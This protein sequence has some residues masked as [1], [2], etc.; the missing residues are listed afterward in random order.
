MSI[1]QAPTLGELF[2]LPEA[3]HRGDFV[4]NLAE[5]AAD[6]G[7]PDDVLD[8]YVVTD[9]IRTSFDKALGFIRDGINSN[10]SR[11]T[12]L[13]GSFGSGKSHFMAV[14]YLLLSQDPRARR[15]R[16]LQDLCAAHQWLDG[17]KFLL[18][19]YH[20]IAQPS[21]EACLL[22]GYVDFVRKRHPGSALPA[23]YLTEDLLKN[24]EEMRASFGDEAF[25]KRLSGDAEASSVDDG[26]G[27]ISADET[28]AWDLPTYLAA[29][30]APPNSA[31]R[32]RLVTALVNTVLTAFRGA[33]GQG[34]EM[35]VP[36]DD[37]LTAISEHAKS[38]G[39]D[40][41]VLFCDELI[42]WL[43]SRAADISF[44]HQE[45]QKL[46][47]LV[48]GKPRALPIISFMARQRDLRELV[49][50]NVLG[51]DKLHFDDAFKH[52][53]GRFKTI[54]LEDTNLP[55][56]ASQRVLR[57]RSEKAREAID[58]AFSKTWRDSAQARS[59]LLSETGTEQDFRKV[60]PF[61]PALIETLIAVSSILQ[62]QRTALKVLMELLIEKRD[63]HRLGDLIPVGDLYEQVAEGAEAFTPMVRARFDNAKRFYES[64]FLP[65]LEK[66]TGHQW[67]S[68]PS[69]P[70][71]QAK[72][73]QFDIGDRLMKTLILA[74][75]VPEAAVMRKLTAQKL[76]ALN[77][78]VIQAPIVGGEGKRV[79][80]ILQTWAGRFGQLK[81]SEDREPTVFLQ[82]TGV[83]VEPLIAEK[84][85][86]GNLGNRRR[87][88]REILCAALELEPS[89]DVHL[90]PLVWRGVRRKIA[91]SFAN[92]RDL[93]LEQLAHQGADWRLI[94]DYPFDR[95][96]HTPREDIL[97]LHEYRA[98]SLPPSRTILWMPSFLSDKAQAELG[99]LVVLEHLLQGETLN[100]VARHMTAVDRA[101]ARNV[102]SSRRDALRAEMRRT[103]DMAY[104]LL[105]EEPNRLHTDMR[106]NREEQ[107]AS[108]WDGFTPQPPVATGMRDA[109]EKLATQAWAEQFPKAPLFERE[110]RNAQLGPV[111]EELSR[112]ASSQSDRGL[113][114][115]KERRGLLQQIAEPLRLAR[116]REGYLSLESFWLDKLERVIPQAGDSGTVELM[117]QAIEKDGSTG[118]TRH[119]RDLIHLTWAEKAHYAF[120]RGD[121]R[122][123]APQPGSLLPT[124]RILEE[125][126]PSEE[127]WEEARR[128]AVELFGLTPQE[129]RNPSAVA[130]LSRQLRD[131]AAQVA[132]KL[133]RFH[134]RLQQESVNL[135]IC[136]S[137]RL[138]TV[139]E[140]RSM[141]EGAREDGTHT[142]TLEAF[143]KEGISA[144]LGAF[145]YVLKTLDDTLTRLE[146]KTM[147]GL[148]SDVSE[149]VEYEGDLAPLKSA[150]A[151]DEIVESLAPVFDVVARAVKTRILAKQKKDPKPMK[152]PVTLPA[153]RD[154]SPEIE[155]VTLLPSGE[156]H[157]SMDQLDAALSE[158]RKKLEEH[159]AKRVTLRWQVEE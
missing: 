76:A 93:D 36:L 28:A 2:I 15:R 157:S 123:D 129:I 68:E 55:E 127:V 147:W 86:E 112:L 116:L 141:V 125:N 94:I 63:T 38:L 111:W 72:K 110:V 138:R 113:V 87:L 20:F 149:L 31:E 122:L 11:A 57:A 7:A 158:V 159:G 43:A 119:L 139:K 33:V 6:A 155:G 128:R 46:V 92:I 133:N 99:D 19:P 67:R 88:I 136:S 23:V 52:W 48:E 91:V 142:A 107:F 83:D 71:E 153:E 108:L 118:L 109:L 82:L 137:D 9:Q 120:Y 135:G 102:L 132:P 60:Y 27:E 62:R 65:Y 84:R 54:K 130:S 49:G 26:W 66:E 85:S 74:A 70:E 22:G 29:L 89:Q 12:Y 115:N 41:L 34:S 32:M 1:V 69:S 47:K 77:H 42:L 30:V 53:E 8:T 56:V 114:E 144:S 14:L 58:Q 37:G 64:E 97:K 40:A 79:L 150:I 95:P 78:G 104:G 156:I 61:S 117:D 145:K 25:L 98:S 103:L 100:E 39:Y 101:E 4:L 51:S 44:V 80:A 152:P 50:D 126:L 90:V 75:L 121:E 24:A 45:A 148:V 154:S 96:S 143:A 16:E 59:T 124:D 134:E 151:E 17:K 105:A 73:L 10:K 106:L 3:V 13:H 18:V 81:V 21:T 140:L 131:Q 146:D 5:V 35:F